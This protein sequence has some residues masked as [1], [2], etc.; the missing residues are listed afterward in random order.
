[1]AYVYR[2]I[3]LDTNQ[4]FYIGMGTDA[5][6]KRAYVRRRKNKFWHNII[7]KTTY[8]VEIIY[9]ELTLEEAHKKEIEFI[10]LYGR[11][12]INT[13][14]LVNLTDGGEGNL[15]W[16]PTPEV[17]EKISKAN[18]GNNK[19]LGKK[20]TDLTK[21]RLSDAHSGKITP[22]E[23]REKIAIGCK[24]GNKTTF[25][26]GH[27]ISDATRK[28]M[29]EA[30]KNRVFTDEHK[31]NISK[32]QLGK[33]RNQKSKYDYIDIN[34]LKELR[35]SNI[36]IKDIAIILGCNARHVERLINIHKI[37]GNKNNVRK[38]A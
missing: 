35:K 30:Q 4:P 26:K 18:K 29:G 23:V 19:W 33:T 3:R 12:N 15:G 13:G 21:K 14:I 5:D 2:H 25:R 28:A 8:E 34:Q 20:H 22:I 11:R 32:G 1:M 7:N 10:A 37:Y 36:K 24:G 31:A 6:Y 16:I 9:D 17:R 27:V 38:R